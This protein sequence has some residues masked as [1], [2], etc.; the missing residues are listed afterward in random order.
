M[1]EHE[2]DGYEP[3]TVMYTINEW[4]DNVLYSTLHTTPFYLKQGGHENE[5]L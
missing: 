1:N 4:M 3:D 2:T 5:N